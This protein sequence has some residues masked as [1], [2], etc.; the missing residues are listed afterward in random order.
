MNWKNSNFQIFHHILGNCHTVVEG[1]RVLYELR[2]DRLFAIKSS[3]AESKRSESKVLASRAVLEDK[4]ETNAQRLL[5]VCNI[6]EQ[7]ARME[8]AQPC[9]DA[10]K[11][12]L[13]FILYLIERLELKT[14]GPIT[15]IEFQKIQPVENALDL[16][17]RA[18][19]DLMISGMPSG[20]LLNETRNSPYA[21][22]VFASINNLVALNRKCMGDNDPLSFAAMTKSEIFANTGIDK[23]LDTFKLLDLKTIQQPDL[24]KLE[25]QIKLPALA[26]PTTKQST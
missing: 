14:G 21:H 11:Q 24:E 7:D 13:A 22:I 6:E 23:R 16:V 8:I 15:A 25:C 2:Q 4:N 9:F 20:E 12:E 10:A 1:L 17:V 5:S 18:H 26:S 3:I 19:T